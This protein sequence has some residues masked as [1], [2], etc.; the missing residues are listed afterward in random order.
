MRRQ[1]G[2]RGVAVILRHL[3]MI[4]FLT[5]LNGESC[6]ICCLL[7]E[8]LEIIVQL[9]IHKKAM[10][11][12]TST[13]TS[14]YQH[15]EPSQRT[16]VQLRQCLQTIVSDIEPGHTFSVVVAFFFFVVV[17]LAVAAVLFLVLAFT[18][19]ASCIITDIPRANRPMKLKVHH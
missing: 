17:G 14:A 6:S 15:E 9:I 10:R 16:A 4:L 12:N 1:V 2:A 19:A 18:A 7:A 5:T 8:L 3:L 11:N 13:Q